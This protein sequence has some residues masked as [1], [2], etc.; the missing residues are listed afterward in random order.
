MTEAREAK[1]LQVNGI[2]QGVGFRPFVYQLATRYG[3]TGAVA[4]TPA[5]VSLTVEGPRSKIAQFI[6]DLT[7]LKP[8]L[9]HILEI[10]ATSEP[11]TGFESFLI[12]K[13]R[14]DDTRTTL[15]SPDVRVCDDCL[16][17]MRDPADRRFRY[18]FINCTHCGPRYT[19]IEDIPYDRP[20]TSM[21]CF[22]MCPLCQ[23]EYDDPCSRR[24]HAQ[25]NACPICGPRLILCDA[26]GTALD[27]QDPVTAAALRLKAGRIVAVKGLGGFH[28]AV[29][30]THPGAVERLRRR[31]QREEKPLALMCADLDRARAI[32]QF[33]K[34]EAD[35][36]TSIQRPIVVVQKRRFTPIVASVAPRNRCFGIMLPYTPLHHLLMDAGFAALVM[37]SANLS[38]EPIVIDNTEAFARL[39]GVA[40]DLLIHNRDIY[41]R[42]D[43]SIVRY[44][45]GHMRPIRRSRGYVPVPVFVKHDLPPILACGAELK[46]TICLTRGRHAFVSQHIGDLE[47]RA[48]EDFFRLTVAHL[49]RL[50]KIEPSIVACDLHPDYRS[51][52][53]AQQ[54]SGITRIHVQ[55]HHAHIAACMAEN[56]AD[57][58]V[59]GLAFDGTGLGTD[60]TIWGGEVLIT[61]Y[62]AFTRAAHLTPV[63]MPGGAAAIKEPWRMAVSHLQDAFG[64]DLAR[65]KL[66]FLNAAGEQWITLMMQSIQKRINCPPTS[67]LGRL[68]DA[69]A[70]IIGLRSQV[71]FEGQAA[72]ELEMVAADAEPGRY[73]FSWQ[74]SDLLRIATAPIVQGVVQDVERGVAA[75]VVSAR[76][77]NTLIDLFEQLCRHLRKTTGIDQVALS[78]GVFQNSRLLVGLTAALQNSGFDLLT[79]RLVPANDGGIALGQAVV[80]AARTTR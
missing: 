80:A 21:R 68:F 67:S 26:Q 29:D 12:L 74:E 71:A 79:H 75:A 77:H 25:P 9:A 55:H 65:L 47:N 41:L 46:N 11:L 3:L 44:S 10:T 31:K 57:G 23:N 20:K 28:L 54:C 72:M 64:Q 76:F 15:V 59:I 58:P 66:P 2:V 45:A 38:Q 48:T 27:A 49:K 16:A 78:G 37:T 61:D 17:E 69:V 62:H 60:G 33:G 32:A 13:S 70:A 19:I 52:R 43:D 5:G 7:V 35:L 53:F 50:L 24:F 51:T 30:A 22:D 14:D 73:P 56:Q 63:P 36:L 40:D 6:N 1:R 34:A 4:N 42:S 39:A 18:P 8:P